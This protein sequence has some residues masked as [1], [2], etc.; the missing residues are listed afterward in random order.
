MP[1]EESRRVYSPAFSLASR[2][3]PSPNDMAEP[4][5]TVIDT[6]VL[7]DWLVFDEPSTRPLVAALEAGR[8][9][10][11][12]T[13]A[14]LAEQRHVIRGLVGSRWPADP[15]A[16]EAAYARWVTTVEAPPRLPA[17]P[18]CTDPDDQIF[19]DLALAHRARWLLTRDRA[20]LKLG[21]RTRAAG[22]EVLTP[23]AW[24][25]LTSAAP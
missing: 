12:S 6:N 23:Q 13:V 19:V 17:T 21:R 20:L 25:T 8:L 18:R 22:T 1:G 7:L 2:V 4:A 11:I 9:R 3:R 15:Q 5:L 14:M 10:W 24:S 16:L